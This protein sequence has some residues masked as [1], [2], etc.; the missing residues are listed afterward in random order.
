MIQYHV[1]MACVECLFVCRIVYW[2][3]HIPEEDNVICDDFCFVFLGS[4]R[5]IYPWS[6]LK[7]SFYK[8]ELSL[9]VVSHEFPKRCECDTVMEC[10]F[11]YHL[12][13]WLLIWVVCCEIEYCTGI[14][15]EWVLSKVSE[16]LCTVDIL[17]HSRLYG[18]VRSIK[19]R[20]IVLQV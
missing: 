4:S 8:D 18:S 15:Y 11:R 17:R 20:L 16:Y 1:I 14:F 3:F 13:I 10:R 12:T 19:Q 6:V 2:L 7:S 5:F 9:L